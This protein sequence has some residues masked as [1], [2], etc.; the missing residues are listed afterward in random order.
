MATAHSS[1][2][3]GAIPRVMPIAWPRLP[4]RDDPAGDRFE[5]AVWREAANLRFRT[6][7]E[8]VPERG[9]EERLH[10]VG[11]H[12]LLSFECREGAGGEHEQDLGPGARAQGDLG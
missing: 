2:G 12:E 4:R 6:E 11:G 7:D 1:R 3:C 5:H 10:M 9:G 8:A